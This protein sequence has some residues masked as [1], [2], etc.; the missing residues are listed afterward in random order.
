MC[1]MGFA[2]KT[3]I[4]ESERRSLAVGQPESQQCVAGLAPVLLNVIFD[5]YDINLRADL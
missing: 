2:G 5:E 3:R 4:A 1:S